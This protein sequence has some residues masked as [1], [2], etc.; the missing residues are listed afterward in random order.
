MTLVIGHSEVP[1]VLGAVAV[2]MT[3]EGSLPVVVEIGVR[4]GDVVCCMGDVKKTIIVILRR[5]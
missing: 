4:D 1:L 2:T 5:C 3:D